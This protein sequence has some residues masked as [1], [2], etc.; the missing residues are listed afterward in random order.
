MNTRIVRVVSIEVVLVILLMLAPATGCTREGI[1]KVPAEP[2]TVSITD[3]MGK[4]V[5][6]PYKPK[7]VVSLYGPP[8]EVLCA[9]GCEGNIVGVSNFCK[10]PPAVKDKPQVGTPDTPSVERIVE[11]KPDIVMAFRGGYGADLKPDIES[12][13][14]QTGIPVIVINCLEPSEIASDIQKIGK[15]F[16]KEDAAERYTSAILR[17]LD[18]VQKRLKG[19]EESKKPRVYIAAAIVGDLV[20]FA[21]G[22]DGDAIVEMAGGINLAADAA[23]KMPRVSPEWLVK[24]QPD[25]LVKLCQGCDYD[26]P[27]PD[28]MKKVMETMSQSPGFNKLDAVKNGRVYALSVDLLMSPRVYVEVAYLAKWFYPELFKDI[29]PENL[30]KE[31]MEGIYGVALKGTWAYPCP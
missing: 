30:H 26:T 12:Q 14:K 31:I 25:V 10:F 4:L 6:A 28:G 27:S 16:G 1:K 7:R 22:M 18:I 2:E 11:L 21:R 5:Q 3:S 19:I 24:E 13:I 8:T 17:P 29:D 20:S 15:I 9:L 23:T